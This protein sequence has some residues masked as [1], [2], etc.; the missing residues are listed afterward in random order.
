ML[1]VFWFARSSAAS[2]CRSPLHFTAPPAERVAYSP[3]HLR[4]G[5]ERTYACRRLAPKL[6]SAS[7]PV[8]ASAASGSGGLKLT[9]KLGKSAAATAAPAASPVPVPHPVHAAS[10][11]TATLGAA[12]GQPTYA[13]DPRYAQPAAGAAYGYESNWNPPQQS[14]HGNEDDDDDDDADRVSATKYR[15]LKKL[16]LAAVEASPVT[17]L[18]ARAQI[19]TVY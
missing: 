18:M 19:S 2:I 5:S 17:R 1:V 10:P 7:P 16:Y 3:R 11:A 12:A 15:K 8:P 13:P 4:R 6:A 14:T 9:F